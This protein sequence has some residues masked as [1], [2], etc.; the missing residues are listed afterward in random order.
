[1]RTIYRT[2]ILLKKNEQ[3]IEDRKKKLKTELSIDQYKKSIID[4]YRLRGL[5]VNVDVTYK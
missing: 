2:K 4:E 3:I 5:E 1:M